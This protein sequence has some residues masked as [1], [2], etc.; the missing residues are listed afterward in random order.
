VRIDT[1]WF[2]LIGRGAGVAVVAVGVDVGGH[3]TLPLRRRVAVSIRHTGGLTGV[4]L[5]VAVILRFTVGVIIAAAQMGSA[6]GL[7]VFTIIII[8]TS[9]T[10]S[11]DRICIK[12]IAIIA[13]APKAVIMVLITDQIATTISVHKT[14]IRDTEAV[15]TLL[16][17]LTVCILQT[18]ASVVT[19]VT[20]GGRVGTVFIHVTSFA[21]SIC[22]AR[23]VTAA[24]VEAVI[25]VSIAGL[26]KPGTV[27]MVLANVN[28]TDAVFTLVPGIAIR[29][30][31]TLASVVSQVT[32]GGGVFTVEGV[33]G[34]SWMAGSP[35]CVTPLALF[36]FV[37]GGDIAELIVMLT[38]RID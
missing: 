12:F 9:R 28:N 11:V 31:L 3:V 5:S 7:G 20:D 24:T 25:M 38:V 19:H 26:I 18:L 16:A 37:G 30:H 15:I 23:T 35:V 4:G 17:I 33:T 32:D 22:V 13:S 14:D 2:A 6:H 10:A 1:S 29:V 8:S 27:R 34:A 21:A 36:R